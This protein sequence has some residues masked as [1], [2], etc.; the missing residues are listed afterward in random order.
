MN[1]T[2]VNKNLIQTS[3]M[4][5]TDDESGT[6]S[7]AENVPQS[8]INGYNEIMSYLLIFPVSYNIFP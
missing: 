4:F 7:L 8:Q 3:E 2:D 6:R 5:L 1:S